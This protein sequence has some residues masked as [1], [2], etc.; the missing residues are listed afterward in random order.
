MNATDHKDQIDGD[1]QA[2]QMSIGRHLRDPKNCPPPP[3]LEDRRLQIYRDLLFN[4]LKNFLSSGFPE[5]RQFYSDERWAELVRT[6]YRDHRAHTPYFSQIGGEF[7]AWLAT[8][9]KPDRIDPP[10]A[11][12][13]AH[14]EYAETALYTAE[15]IPCADEVDAD[16]DVTEN[17]PV[18]SPLAQMFSY[19]W[20]VHTIRAD[21]SPWTM[22]EQRTHLLLWRNR[23]DRVQYLLISEAVAGLIELVRVHAEQ[24]PPVSG[25]AIAD[26]LIEHNPGYAAHRAAALAELKNLHKLGVIA[27]AIAIRQ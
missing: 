26:R 8:E 17:M 15:D 11:A 12:E 5:L 22:P 1:F 9:R 23:R 10:F 16:A 19:R 14:F 4:N 18:L 7:V 3:G 20:P 27:G 2:L 24:R 21:C 6:F 25:T 13:L